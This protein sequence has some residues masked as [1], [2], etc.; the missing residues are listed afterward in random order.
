MKSWVVADHRE[1]LGNDVADSTPPRQKY[2]RDQCPVVAVP[3]SALLSSD[4]PRL[5]GQNIDH[6]RVLAESEVTFPPIIV[7]RS[8]LRV[9]DGM[10][11][12]LAAKFRGQS[13]IEVQFFDGD[14]GD[15]FVLAVKEN[16]AHGLPLSLTDRTTAAA[17]IISYHPQW[18]DRTIASFSGLSTKTV[19][20]IRRRST[21]DFPQLNA[22][23]GLDGRVRPHNTAE[24]RRIAG[25]LMA[26]DPD[27]SLRAVARSAGIS[28]GTAQDV[29][30]RL[31]RGESPVLPKRHKANRRKVHPK[32]DKPA[33]RH[34]SKVAR[35]TSVR[36]RA[37]ILQNL[38]QDP[39][40]RFADT[41]RVLLRLLRVLAIGTRGWV[42]LID[43]LPKHCIPIVSDA[44]RACA[45]AWQELAEQLERR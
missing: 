27:A 32:R 44:A 45:D 28:I 20:A 3:L 43:N 24:G 15:A 39:S 35:R 37:L 9:I 21:E 8:T 26:G 19:S 42:Q 25:N 40:L 23:V 16:I 36:D 31:Q 5:A 41:G 33:G 29:R 13:E 38:R 4:S 12:L 10:H 17:R 6:V 18:S 1:T 34:D 22:R 14:E 2:Q 30:E 7:N 11:R